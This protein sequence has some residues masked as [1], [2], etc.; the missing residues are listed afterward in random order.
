MKL[1]HRFVQRFRVDGKQIVAREERMVDFVSKPIHSVPA[2]ARVRVPLMRD[3]KHVL[4]WLLRISGMALM[5]SPVLWIVH[6]IT[7]STL[8]GMTVVIFVSIVVAF[9][10]L[11]NLYILVSGIIFL[12]DRKTKV[13]IPFDE[14][15]EHT[16]PLE[17]HRLVGTLRAVERMEDGDLLL[18]DAWTDDRRRVVEGHDLVLDRPTADPLIVRLETAPEMLGKGERVR[19]S[20]LS[21]DA[22]KMLALGGDESLRA[23]TLRVGDRIEVFA[24]EEPESQALDRLE[25]GGKSRSFH[26]KEDSAYRGSM[27]RADVVVCHPRSIVVLRKLYD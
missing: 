1:R 9:F 17:A 21:D 15:E 3:L 20:E 18:R 2:R 12:F 8:G 4:S 27:A 26:R 6:L 24:H 7:R 5:A 16:L 23:L 14:D 13:S 22:R 25:L 19:A 10:A 11:L